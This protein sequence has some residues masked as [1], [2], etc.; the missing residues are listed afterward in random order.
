MFRWFGRALHRT[1][2][3]SDAPRVG[4]AIWPVF[5]AP[6]LLA[7]SGY[8]AAALAGVDVALDVP[9]ARRRAAR[10]ACSTA[11]G[12]GSRAHRPRSCVGGRQLAHR[13]TVGA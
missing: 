5:G 7:V 2:R 4:A 12:R 8:V 11:A 9:A 10:L 1:G 13:M 6:L 3:R